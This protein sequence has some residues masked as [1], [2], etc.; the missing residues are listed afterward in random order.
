[1]LYFY[2]PCYIFDGPNGSPGYCPG[3]QAGDIIEE[4]LLP[5][6]TRSPWFDRELFRFVVALPAGSD[7]P[8]DGWE[9]KTAAEV[10]ADYPHADMGG[11]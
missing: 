6:G 1:M 9:S 3:V 10:L 7:V 8:G 2:T 4:A 11:S 5:P